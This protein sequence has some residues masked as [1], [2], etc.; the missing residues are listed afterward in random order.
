MMIQQYKYNDK[1]QIMI[2]MVFNKLPTWLHVLTIPS[3]EGLKPPKTWRCSKGNTKRVHQTSLAGFSGP[4]SSKVYLGL[5]FQV[6]LQPDQ[7]LF[8]PVKFDLAAQH[9]VTQQQQA[10][11]PKL[12][13]RLNLIYSNVLIQRKVTFTQNN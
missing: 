12:I 10:L 8:Q 4:R 6:K 7:V 1:Q 9:I 2:S 11:S 5:C 13:K 3:I